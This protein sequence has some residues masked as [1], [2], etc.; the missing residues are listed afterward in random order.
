MTPQAVGSPQSYAVTHSLRC[1]HISAIKIIAIHSSSRIRYHHQ[2]H[3]L[4]QYQFR[5]IES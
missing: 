2:Q 1:H 3:Q 5:A 4:Q